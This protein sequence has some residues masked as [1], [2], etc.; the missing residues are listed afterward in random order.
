MWYLSRGMTIRCKISRGRSWQDFWPFT[1]R[2]CGRSPHD[3]VAV[4]PKMLWPFTP[5]CCGR[6]P[7]DFKW[8]FTENR[9]LFCIGRSSGPVSLGWICFIHGLRISL[10]LKC[11]AINL[12]PILIWRHRILSRIALVSESARFVWSIRNF[13]I[14]RHIRI[15]STFIR[16][17]IIRRS[18]ASLGTSDQFIVSYI[19]SCLN[20]IHTLVRCSWKEQL[21]RS[22]S[23][24]I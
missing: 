5:R 7:L 24:K 23:S 20:C 1:P 17:G 8:P 14:L 15:Y 13:R 4:H 6:S 16:S 18:V 10:E 12:E 2:C 11:V 9:V 3:I 22:L 21:G 19:L